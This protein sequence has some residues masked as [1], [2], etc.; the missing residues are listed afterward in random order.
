MIAGGLIYYYG[1]ELKYIAVLINTT[2]NDQ[3]LAYIT[4]M[5]LRNKW[6][7]VISN[8]VKSIFSLSIFRHT[9]VKPVLVWLVMDLFKYISL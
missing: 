7:E 5:P 9:L 1:T 8:E 2:I 6:E 3:N 4:G